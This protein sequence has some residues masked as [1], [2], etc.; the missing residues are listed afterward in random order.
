MARVIKKKDAAVSS[1]TLNKF[2]ALTDSFKSEDAILID[3]DYTERY[4]PTGSIVFDEVLKLKGMPFGGRVVHIHGKEHGGKSTICYSIVGSYQRV[5]NQP[6]VIFDFEGTTTLEYLRAVGVNTSRNLLAVF[7]VTDIE[8][9]I[10]KAIEYM[11]AG[12]KLFVF[13]SIPKMKSMYD[14]KDIK[15]G[16]AFKASVGEHAR[17]MVRFFDILGP[18]AMKHDCLFLMVNQIRARIDGSQEAM[19]AQKYPSYTN[20]P[21]VL[22]GGNSVRYVPSLMLEVNVQKAL[23]GATDDPFLMEP[24]P[25]EN[26]AK[27]VVATRVKVRVLKNKVTM[28]SYREYPI[29][30]RTGKGLDDWISVRELARHY[31]LIRNK[32]ARYLVGKE[33]E[34]IMMYEN[35]EAAIKDLVLDQN[36]EVLT[37][38]REL[39]VEVI[40]EDESNTFNTQLTEAERFLI[41]DLEDIKKSSDEDDEIDMSALT[42]EEEDF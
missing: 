22:P 12:V 2:A 17:T 27:K 7:K 8:D 21:Y 13:D 5:L 3:E 40:R 10:K 34:P 38:L 31:G 23:K 39:L 33:E 25:E 1:E 30:L 11:E 29:Y 37:R 14:K 42:P 9:C 4:F 24:E 35:K 28:G 19:L 26:S 15:S 18:Y 36:L 16:A 32:G 6:A 41:G 20:L